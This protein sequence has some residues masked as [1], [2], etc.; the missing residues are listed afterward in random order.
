MTVALT[1]PST[2]SADTFESGSLILPADEEWQDAGALQVYGLVHLL[3]SHGVPVHWAILP[4]KVHNESDL[5]ATS[6]PLA[7]GTPELRS[8]AAGPWVVSATDVDDDL[9]DL[10]WDWQALHRDVAVHRATEDFLAPIERTLVAAPFVTILADG[11]EANAF[12]YLNAAGIPTQAGTDW[13]PVQ[14]ESYSDYP[15][16]LSVDSLTGSAQVPND[17]GLFGED[18]HPISSTLITVHLDIATVPEGLGDE[19][20]SY[21]Q[22][23]THQVFATCES[24]RSLEVAGDGILTTAGVVGGVNPGNN[25]QHHSSDHPLVQHFGEFRPSGGEV[26]SILLAPDSAYQGGTEVFLSKLG[27]PLGSRDVLVS[28]DVGGGG[29]ITYLSGHRYPTDV[30][31]SQDQETNGVRFLLNTL[32]LDDRLRQSDLPEVQ[33]ELDAPHWEFSPLV[34]LKMDWK[35]DGNW[36]RDAELRLRLPT[37]LPLPE[38]LGAAVFDEKESE[39]VWSLGAIDDGEQGT[40]VLD[41]ELPSPGIWTLSLSSRFRIGH[42][43]FE[44]D[45]PTEELLYDVDNDEDGFGSLEDCDDDDPE[46]HPQVIEICGD[47]LDQDCDGKDLPCDV[48]PPTGGVAPGCKWDCRGGGVRL[49]QLGLALAFGLSLGL[50]RRR[51]D[52][53]QGP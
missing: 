9:V 33:L 51:W 40:R 8:Y 53:S 47:G 18:T 23:G 52:A 50:R 21:L 22:A 28:R 10:I 1:G 26:L 42:T 41:I 20:W 49:G 13:P 16:I 39:L 17:G 34:A 7:G 14:L 29:R 27:A 46:I 38:D 25:L 5:L 4:G 2:A 35:F 19:I 15:D 36:V 30:P 31:P 11:N 24:I 43:V 45:G 3:L 32:F 44:V 6:T 37:D 12:R 48:A